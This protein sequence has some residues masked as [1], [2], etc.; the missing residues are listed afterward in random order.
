MR[1]DYRGEGGEGSGW[2]EPGEEGWEEKEKGF[3]MSYILFATS[4]FFVNRTCFRF[5]TRVSVRTESCSEIPLEKSK[6]NSREVS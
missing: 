6:P 1:R 4:R 2:G 5:S 3:F